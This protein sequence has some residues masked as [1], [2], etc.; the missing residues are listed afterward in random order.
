MIR[1]DR[2]ALQLFAEV[3]LAFQYF[4]CMGYRISTIS[5][6]SLTDKH[7]ETGQGNFFTGK[8][9]K[10]KSCLIIQKI[11]ETN[12]RV[13]IRPSISNISIRQLAIVFMDNT[14]F[15]TN[16]VDFQGN[17]QNIIKRYTRLYKA[18]GGK[19]Q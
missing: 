19:V 4:I 14:S 2:K 12:K 11:E 5:Y 1:V 10:V 6:G 3:L 15:Y 13:I 9:C 16:R 17:I 8:S 18:T 7:G